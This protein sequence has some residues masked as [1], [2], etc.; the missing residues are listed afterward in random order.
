MSLL[1]QMKR[2]LKMKKL[3]SYK[4]TI[5][6]YEFAELIDNLS[7][8]EEPDYDLLRLSLQK[9]MAEGNVGTLPE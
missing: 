4:K 6:F 1:S 5:N 9:V 3:C 7:F 2:N 8:D